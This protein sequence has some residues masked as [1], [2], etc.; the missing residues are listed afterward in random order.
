MCAD[1]V[2]I[3]DAVC[4]RDCAPAVV[5]IVEDVG[6]HTGG[7]QLGRGV[8][9]GQLAKDS[10]YSPFLPNTLNLARWAS[11]SPASREP[12]CQEVG[13]TGQAPNQQ[14]L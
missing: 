9:S 2:P 12:S 6:C 1:A 14:E 11:P 13:G 7:E 10:P 3:I 4:E 8:Q 5:Q